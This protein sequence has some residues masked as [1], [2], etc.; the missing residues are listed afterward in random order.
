MKKSVKR[1]LD[2]YIRQMDRIDL[3]VIACVILLS[4]FG[5]IMIY[6][7]SAYSCSTLAKYNYDS[8][9]LLKKQGIF[10]LAG[11][12][13]MLLLQYFNY[14]YLQKLAP[15]IFL[16]SVGSLFLLRTGLAVRSHGAARWIRLGPVQLQVAE[17]VKIAM[18]IMIAAFVAETCQSGTAVQKYGSVFVDILYDHT[19]GM[20]MFLSNNLSSALIILGIGF[21]LSF[22]FTNQEKLHGII[23]GIGLIGIFV[24]RKLLAKNLPTQKQLNASSSSFRMGRFYAW[25]DPERYAGDQGFQPL[26]GKYAVGLR[27][28]IWQGVRQQC[29]K[30]RQNSRG[31]ERYDLFYRL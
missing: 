4:V 24:G 28:F 1:S 15:I 2:A 6:S 19:S 20:V 23:A 25:I 10:V 27:R 12:V 22:V 17:L 14:N 31:T 29:A 26:Q 13:V 18:V 21:M 3:R 8:L 30:I 7:A 16:V 11:I 5:L 9:Y